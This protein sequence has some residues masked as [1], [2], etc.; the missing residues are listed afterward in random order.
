MGAPHTST[1]KYQR[2]PQSSGQGVERLRMDKARMDVVQVS[3]VMK[4][5]ER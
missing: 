3:E 5:M 1:G 4:G 2:T